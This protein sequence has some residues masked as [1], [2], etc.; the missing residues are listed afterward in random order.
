MLIIQVENYHDFKLFLSVPDLIYKN[1]SEY[2]PHIKQ[3][4]KSILWDNSEARMWIVKHNEEL[5]GRIAA[6][7]NKNDVGGMGF[8][9]SINDKS[10]AKVLFDEGTK[11]LRSQKVKKVEAPVNFGARDKFWGLM[12]KGFKK[13]SYQENYNP[14]Y[15]QKLFELNG[16]QVSFTQSTQEVSTSSFQLDK[17]KALTLRYSDS[18]VTFQHITRNNLGKY[19]NDFAEVYNASWKEHSHFTPLSSTQVLKTLKSI[20]S[21]IREDLMWFAYADSKPI[22]FYLSIIEVNQIFQHLNGNLNWLGKLKFFYFKAVTPIK[23][24]R[25]LVFGVAPSYQGTWV[26]AGLMLKVF[27]VISNDKHI[28]TNE[29]AW[30]GDFNPKMLKLLSSIGA[31][32]TKQHVTY[33]K[34]I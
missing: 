31:K 20:K 27:E 11:W 7:I 6:F 3:E 1:D 8:F 10:V 29:L 32:E 34:K 26:A 19:A 17:I 4:I 16:F 33:E 5:V 13:P 2:I 30:I 12:V 25:G 14:T 18:N 28:E 22:A 15:Y 24:I 23:R 9:E 21:I